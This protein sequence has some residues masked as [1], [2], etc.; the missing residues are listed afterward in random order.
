MIQEDDYK[1][2]WKNKDATVA[3]TVNNALDDTGYTFLDSYQTDTSN[4]SK[5]VETIKEPIKDTQTIKEPIKDTQTIKEPIKDDTHIV[6]R[7]RY[8]QDG[9]TNMDPVLTGVGI[10]G[11]GG[12]RTISGGSISQSIVQGEGIIICSNVITHVL[13]KSSNMT[14]KSDSFP[15]DP[16][17]AQTL[18]ITP[19]TEPFLTSDRD[20][21]STSV[22]GSS[23][24]D[25]SRIF[26]PFMN[27]DISSRDDVLST[28]RSDIGE[29]KK[30]NTAV[31]KSSTD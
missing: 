11:Q 1:L 16:L 4:S 22:I 5:Q 6:K 21:R 31:Q 12:P 18:M 14:L 26:A 8:L 19:L 29:T 15:F 27:E 9:P 2:P 25:N 20:L 23:R 3:T 30:L 17:K 28:V 24:P 10:I 7:V 13:T